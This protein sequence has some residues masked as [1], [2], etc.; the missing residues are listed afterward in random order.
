MLELSPGAWY[1]EVR[2]AENYRDQFLDDWETVLEQYHGPGYRPDKSPMQQSHDPEN[3]AF[4]WL[5]LMVPQVTASNPRVRVRSSRLGAARLGAKAHTFAVNR[6]IRL[7]NMKATAELHATDYGL[8]YCV[9]YVAPRPQPGTA[10]TG[11]SPRLP[12]YRRLSPRRYLQDPMAIEF[13]EQRWRSH[14]VVRDKDDMLANASE[15]PKEGWNVDSIL[16][17]PPSQGLDEVRGYQDRAAT[18][19]YFVDRKEVSY[20]VIWVPELQY[21]PKRG[22]DKGYNGTLLFLG[23]GQSYDSAVDDARWIREP[24]PYYGPRWG[25]Y[26]TAGAYI[27]PDDATPLS[28]IAGTKA[29]A[30]HLNAVARANQRAVE[31][32]KRMALVSNADPSLEV[33]VTEGR[34]GYVYTTNS[35][36]IQKNVVQ[37]ELGGLTAEMLAAEDRARQ[38]LDRNTGLPEAMRGNIEGGATATEVDAAMSGGAIRVNHHVD[39]FRDFQVRNIRTASW[40]LEF[41]DRI[42]AF[43]LGEEAVRMMLDETGEQMEEIWY[44]PSLGKGQRYEDFDDYEFE[45]ELYSMERTSE[46]QAQA[47]AQELDFLVMQVGPAM[48]QNPHVRWR[49]YLEKRGELRGITDYGRLF[50]VDMA[51]ELGA[52]MMQLQEPLGQPQPTGAKPQQRLQMDTHAR[53]ANGGAPSRNRDRKSMGPSKMLKGP[54]AST[55]APEAQTA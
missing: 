55:A 26:Q 21:D 29:Q 14:L 47:Q 45:I 28:P 24:Q 11:A 37:M 35:E 46:Q 7:A 12:S 10:K 23:V 15:N 18:S 48:L 8:K 3:H 25:P 49:E 2:A 54:K 42:P 43:P 53:P 44:G 9:G 5:S 52:M 39:K 17:L 32:Y 1:D 20:W 13:D 33:T 22:P 27:V 36:D 34:H 50:D 31:D 6:W 30:D 40:Y 51:R 4:E 41:D 16:G 19:M 38:S